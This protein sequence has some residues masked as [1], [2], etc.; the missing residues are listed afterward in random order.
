M[1]L[2]AENLLKYCENLVF[3]ENS[4]LLLWALL[5]IYRDLN[6]K[7]KIM[8]TLNILEKGL[9]NKKYYS[10]NAFS[11]SYLSDVYFA[12]EYYKKSREHSKNVF[13]YFDKIEEADQRKQ[14]LMN[15]LDDFEKK[16]NYEVLSQDKDIIDILRKNAIYDAKDIISNDKF[17]EE[18]Y[19]RRVLEFCINHDHFDIAQ[20]IVNR[21]DK[22]DGNLF[23]YKDYY[24]YFLGEKYLEYPGES[25]IKESSECVDRITRYKS[26]KLDLL[27]NIAE[28]FKIPYY[29]KELLEIILKVDGLLKEIKADLD[30]EKNDIAMTGFII[31][32]APE[33]R[34]ALYLIKV[35]LLQEAFKWIDK[36]KGLY[37]RS[38]ILY[39]A[40]LTLVTRYPINYSLE[41]LKNYELAPNF[42]AQIISKI[43]AK[44]LIDGNNLESE[45]MFKQAIDIGVSSAEINIKAILN[46]YISAKKYK[47]LVIPED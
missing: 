10:N 42:K 4:E 27:V 7:S 40:V 14:L 21:M 20:E 30:F 37:E 35:G 15:Y 32:P 3:K 11:S 36:I 26:L 19:A 31:K 2:E 17:I 47:C 22:R 18:F 45:K 25:F 33:G 12:L 38:E 1:R 13:I 9:A 8:G 6:N 39:K 34:I 16:P 29:K 24:Y 44:Y 5:D 41:I 28:K 46:D 23:F 43:A